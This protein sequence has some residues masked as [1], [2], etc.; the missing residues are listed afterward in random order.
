MPQRTS[1]RSR[2]SPSADDKPSAP[3]I[4]FTLLLLVAVIGV[5]YS[6]SFQGPF[7]FDDTTSIVENPSIRSLRRIGEVLYPARQGGRTPDGRPV[8][9]LSLAI[10]YAISELQVWSYHAF[11]LLVHLLASLTLFDLARRT[12]LLPYFHERYR[13]NALWLALAIALIWGVHPLQTI[14]VT[15]IVQRAES[16][17]ALFYLLVLYCV[18][19]G[20]TSNR[21]RQWFVLAV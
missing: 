6:N 3:R 15:Y 16:M 12:L 10:N 11:N 9:S 17:V 1:V 2:Q 20:E 5:A 8:V 18:L 21:R 7:V 4:G 14:A 19:R 13:D